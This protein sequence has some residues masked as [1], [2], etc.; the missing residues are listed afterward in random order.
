MQVLV[1]VSLT[2]FAALMI[3]AVALARSKYPSLG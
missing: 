1:A 2:A 3:A